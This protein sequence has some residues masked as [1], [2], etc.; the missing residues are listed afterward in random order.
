MVLT[1]SLTESWRVFFPIDSKEQK[2]KMTLVV[3]LK[4]YTE[5][6]KGQF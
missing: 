6:L 5:I 2:L 1:T 3:T 4:L